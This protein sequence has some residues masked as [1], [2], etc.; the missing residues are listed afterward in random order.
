[1]EKDEAVRKHREMWNAIADKIEA[2][3]HGIDI[4]KEKIVFYP[5]KYVK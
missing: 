4:Y 1:M 2:R 3:K 5:R